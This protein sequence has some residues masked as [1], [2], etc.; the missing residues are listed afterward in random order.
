MS[1][2]KKDKSFNLM[3][4]KNELFEQFM[5]E[6]PAIIFVHDENDDIVYANS[7]AK[8]YFTKDSLLGLPLL[9][10]LPKDTTDK[11]TRLLNEAKKKGHAKTII[12]A[13]NLKNNQRHIFKSLAFM[14]NSNQEKSCT[15]T[16]HV[17]VTQQHND[18][19][20]IVKLQQVLNNSPV[21]IVITDIN[22]S[23]EH[24][25]P[26]FT[27]TTGYALEEVIGK[28]PRILK[29]DFHPEKAYV[30]LW[31]TIS[32]N[33]VWTGTFRNIKKSGED[34]WESAIIAP[35]ENNKGKITNYIAI[36]QE[37]TE[38]VYLREQLLL[39]EDEKII[40][41]EKTLET[42]VAIVEDRDTYTG[43]HSQRVASYCRMI[44]QKMKYSIQ[45]CDLIY[46]AGI[47]HDIGKISTPDNILLK[48]GKLT[49]LEYDLIKEHVSTSY[50]ILS[51]IPMYKEIADIVLCHHERY[52]G[53]G[54]PR[55]IKGDD[56]SLLS[57]IM[58]VADA[59]DAMT[60]SR[61]Y[62]GRKSIS[63]A[64]QELKAGSLG[65]F[66]PEVVKNAVEVLADVVIKDD[67]NQLPKTEMEKERFAYFYRDQITR[68]YNSDYLSFILSHNDTK[69]YI[70]IN[71]LYLHNFSNYNEKYGWIEGD[72][73]LKLFVDTL[74]DEFPRALIF[75]VYGDD[76]ILLSEE[77]LDVDAH[78]LEQLDMIAKNS[79]TIS[80][81]HIDLRKK[82]VTNINELEWMM[83]DYS[84]V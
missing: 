77:H 9:D 25:N 18:N 62:R 63:A 4:D 71:A 82:N 36:K 58:I 68:A 15:G 8:A 23:I 13:E 75:R 2:Q 6:I 10:V 11:V 16:I 30:K 45:E 40:N 48:P 84:S 22:G 72:K 31:N 83:L 17:D 49:A 65:Q 20:E 53:K 51:G 50:N 70:C 60:T 44:A 1:R 74:I 43:G 69:K 39:K 66:H 41:F 35:V 73:F 67:I 26:H 61:I 7:G 47:L 76:F 34:Y 64:I 21:S 55:G 37:I 59:F 5:E 54:Y 42:F 80:Q 33:Q 14:I 24:V 28:N 27:Q 56:I 3:N 32:H 19:Q 46:R 81:H 57:H 52:D 78:K 79:I 29:S 38:Q 12:E